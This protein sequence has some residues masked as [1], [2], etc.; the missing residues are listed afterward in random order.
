MALEHDV[1]ASID[2]APALGAISRIFAQFGIVAA[3]A[4]HHCAAG[5]RGI[6]S[7]RRSSGGGLSIKVHLWTKGAGLPIA[8]ELTGGQVSHYR[9]YGG[10]SAFKARGPAAVVLPPSRINLPAAQAT[11]EA[12]TTTEAPMDREELS[13]RRALYGARSPGRI[14]TRP[15]PP[16]KLI[17]FILSVALVGFWVVVAFLKWRG[18]TLPM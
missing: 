3:P 9:N 18:V 5:A 14:K 13:R 11:L 12:Q 17:W 15:R 2:G 16:S 6:R 4:G 7:L 10:G 1:D 8:T